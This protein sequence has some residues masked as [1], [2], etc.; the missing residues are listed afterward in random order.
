[1]RFNTFSLESSLFILAPAVLSLFI[2]VPAGAAIINHS[3]TG[4]CN[5][6]NAVPVASTNSYL[7][8]EDRSRNEGSIDFSDTTPYQM[9]LEFNFPIGETEFITT[10]V[11]SSGDDWL[12][13]DITFFSSDRFSVELDVAIP[14]F[15]DN[16]TL[17]G[18]SGMSVVCDQSSFPVSPTLEKIM[19]RVAF[20][21]AMDDFFGVFTEITPAT[22]GTQSFSMVMEPRL[23]LL[24]VLGTLF[25]LVLGCTYLG[26]CVVK[27]RVDSPNCMPSQQPQ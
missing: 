17:C 24:P 3:A 23:I 20:N 16:L 22:A 11:N 14:S 1:M 6:S 8:C 10:V 27:S 25:L 5:G 7:P 13:F 15:V 19:F 26:F 12:E 18:I 21:P 9:T 2:Q 4:V